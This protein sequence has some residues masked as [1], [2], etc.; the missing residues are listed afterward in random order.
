[1]YACTVRLAV[2]VGQEAD[3][4]AWHAVWFYM[5][6]RARVRALSGLFMLY[7]VKSICT[8][9]LEIY[10]CMHVSVHRAKFCKHVVFVHV[11]VSTCMLCGCLVARPPR[12]VVM[13]STLAYTVCD[14][15]AF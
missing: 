1:M 11:C 7:V 5:H 3:W 14:A 15:D 12:Y 4:L 10:V 8:V 13:R 6:V 2:C 9:Q